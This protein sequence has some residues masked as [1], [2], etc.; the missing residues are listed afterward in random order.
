MTGI[1]GN[2]EGPVLPQRV[3]HSIEIAR[4]DVHVA[5]I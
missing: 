2:R 4:C 1:N 3:L 5:W